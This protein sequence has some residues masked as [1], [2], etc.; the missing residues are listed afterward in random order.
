MSK[1]RRAGRRILNNARKYGVSDTEKNSGNK[2]ALAFLHDNGIGK[3]YLVLLFVVMAGLIMILT[4]ANQPESNQEYVISVC[5]H[6]CD[7]G[8]F[9]TPEPR[10]LSGIFTREDTN[11]NTN[12]GTREYTHASTRFSASDV[13]NTVDTKI[14]HPGIVNNDENTDDTYI[15]EPITE[16]NPIDM[17]PPSD[18]TTIEDA[19]APAAMFDEIDEIDEGYTLTIVIKTHGDGMAVGLQNGEM[20]SINPL[21]PSEEAYEISEIV[22]GDR[23]VLTAGPQEDNHFVHWTAFFTDDS[24]QSFPLNLQTSE[25]PVSTCIFIMPEADV[26]IVIEFSHERP[27]YL[28]NISTDVLPI[29]DGVVPD[30]DDTSA[31]TQKE[32]TIEK[33]ITPIAFLD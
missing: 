10:L 27:D 3:M 25:P 31:N 30:T 12:V 4:T 26:T 1:H 23:F 8:C 15:K 11:D 18:M 13:E 7:D 17:Y 5:A 33:V 14:M 2:R 19:V 16:H 32:E 20:L 24:T 28:D 9:S 22:S 6:E 29:L 21:T